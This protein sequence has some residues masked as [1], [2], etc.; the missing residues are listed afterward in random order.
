MTISPISELEISEIILFEM[1]L[2]ISVAIASI[3]ALDTGRFWQALISPVMILFLSKFSLL[4]SFLI[5]KDRDV[6]HLF[7]R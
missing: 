7:H 6:L 2:S 5:Y 3:W 1:V 4:S